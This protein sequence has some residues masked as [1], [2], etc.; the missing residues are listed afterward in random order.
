MYYLKGLA[1][2]N[3]DLGLFGRLSRQDLSERDQQAARD[4]YQSVKQLVDQ[5][6]ASKY[7]SDARVRAERSPC[8]SRRRCVRSATCRTPAMR[9]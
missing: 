8:S 9:G 3:E 5:F 7:A 2:F 1:N 4:A 6:P